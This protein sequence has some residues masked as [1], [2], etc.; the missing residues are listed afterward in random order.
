MLVTIT[1]ATE[2][3]ED[4][5]K[6]DAPI[7]V[8][9]SLAARPKQSDGDEINCNY[10]VQDVVL[11]SGGRGWKKGDKFRWREDPDGGNSIS[12]VFEVDEV[13]SEISEVDSTIISS[14]TDFGS[15][16]SLL[17]DMHEKIVATGFFAKKNI[18]IVGNGIYL[19]TSAETIYYRYIRARPN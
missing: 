19:K 1:S 10:Y 17:A 2:T 11:Q 15:V 13:I 3:T 6:R 8:R 9:L 18:Q 12:V 5:K 7:A 14:D 4:G 16:S